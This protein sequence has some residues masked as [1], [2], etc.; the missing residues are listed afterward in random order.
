[1]APLKKLRSS[2]DDHTT[3][4][5]LGDDELIVHACNLD[6][7]SFGKQTIFDFA[8]HRRIEHYGLI[9]GQPGVVGPTEN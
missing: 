4:A 2:L 8:R 6:D 7:C 1:M 9:T 3:A 5:N